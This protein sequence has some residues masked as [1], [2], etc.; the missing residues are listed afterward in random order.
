MKTCNK[1]HIEKPLADFN[2][3]S[4]SPDGVRYTCKPC[5][6]ANT[7]KWKH[8]HLEQNTATSKAWYDKNKARVVNAHRVL[9]AN[10]KERYAEYARSW[11]RN[12]KERELEIAKKSR[13]KSLP[14][15]MENNARRRAIAKEATPV[16]ANKFFMQEA[17]ELAKLRTQMTGIK[18]EVDHI[19][20]LRSP[21]V[22]GLHTHTNLQVITKQENLAKRH[23][24]WPDM[25]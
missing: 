10:N 14:A 25:P 11:R 8:E 2:K 1:C 3:Q 18:W 19:I 7:T 12:N 20:P 6:V 23:W 17:Y 22:C 13:D 5:S 24:V 15:R 4:N 9:R 16:W 21:I